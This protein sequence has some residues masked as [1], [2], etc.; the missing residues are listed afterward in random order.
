[1]WIIVAFLALIF[2]AI[3]IV[4]FQFSSLAPKEAKARHAEIALLFA[5]FACAH[6]V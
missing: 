2:V 5:N 1:L 4:V 3:R 6:S